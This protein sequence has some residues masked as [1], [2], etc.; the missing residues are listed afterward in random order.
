MLIVTVRAGVER[1]ICS[2]ALKELVKLTKDQAGKRSV[3]VLVLNRVSAVWKDSSVRTLLP[4]VLLK[5][6][7]VEGTRVVTNNRCGA[8]Q[9]KSDKVLNVATGVVKIETVGNRE[10]SQGIVVDG[11]KIGKSWRSWKFRRMPKLTRKKSNDE[12]NLY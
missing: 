12:E 7:D 11:I 9:I 1:G 4:H 6:I 10:K 3:V 5:Y 8:E 2:A